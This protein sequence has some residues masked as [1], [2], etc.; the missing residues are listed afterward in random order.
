MRLATFEFQTVINNG[1]ISIPAEFL[2]NVEQ[3]GKNIT[4][5]VSVT[6]ERQ[7]YNF[8]DVGIDTRGFKFDREYANER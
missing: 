1:T 8:D 6:S 4:V 7:P 3:E 2:K 5:M